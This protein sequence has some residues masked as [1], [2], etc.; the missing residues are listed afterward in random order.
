M[1]HSEPLVPEIFN[2]TL[3]D[4]A[5]EY[6][7]T[8]S[9]G[10]KYFSIHCR[11][12]FAI[13]IAFENAIADVGAATA[14]YLTIKANQVYNSPEKMGWSWSSST[15]TAPKIYCGTDEAGVVVEILAWKAIT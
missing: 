8:L 4:A 11:T 15:E 12:A 6:S 3:T 2:L 10:T 1:T 5:T 13:R 14:P 7:Q 9:I